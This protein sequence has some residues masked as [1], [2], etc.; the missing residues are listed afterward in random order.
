MTHEQAEKL[1]EALTDLIGAVLASAGSDGDPVGDAQYDLAE[2]LVKTAAELSPGL[3]Y[4]FTKAGD[5]SRTI[6]TVPPGSCA[7]LRTRPID[8][9]EPAEV[10]R[11]PVKQEWDVTI[12]PEEQ[13]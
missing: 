1:A 8:P 5:K 13:P 11:P 12:P 2:L 7:T 9:P 10:V 4:T 6:C 3:R